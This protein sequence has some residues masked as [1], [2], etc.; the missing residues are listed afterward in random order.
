MDERELD[1]LF[2]LKFKNFFFL[3]TR[4]RE[5]LTLKRSW[6][7]ECSNFFTDMV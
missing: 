1:I 4:M 7:P 3:H 6:M 5:R 2:K